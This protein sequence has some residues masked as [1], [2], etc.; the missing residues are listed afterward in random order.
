MEE[1]K[2]E[3]CLELE[4][5]SEE[6]LEALDLQERNEEIEALIEHIKD[7]Y[8][9]YAMTPVMISSLNIVLLQLLW[10]GCRRASKDIFVDYILPTKSEAASTKRKVRDLCSGAW[11]N[12]KKHLLD[13]TAQKEIAETLSVDEKYFVSANPQ[14]EPLLD[15]D[16][17]RLL[18]WYYYF[19]N[20][21]LYLDGDID[22]HL[23]KIFRDACKRR[24]L[25]KRSLTS[26]GVRAYKLRQTN[27]EIKLKNLR[28]TACVEK[29]S[30][31]I[32]WSEDK[33][34]LDFEYQNL[35]GE[36]WQMHARRKPVKD[37]DKVLY[38]IRHLE[39]SGRNI[40]QRDDMDVLLKL[41]SG[42]FWGALDPLL[43][44]K[45]SLKEKLALIEQWE[46]KWGEQLTMLKTKRLLL[47]SDLQKQE[48]LMNY[49]Q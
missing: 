46:Q 20:E 5:L 48:R 4:P 25:Y 12:F 43:K 11:K 24:L 37:F 33:L 23:C 49:E 8:K 18:F 35:V 29:M 28:E 9:E 10:T 41:S 44:E 16:G 14:V 39:V 21:A 27:H 42:D 45:D 40:I 30:E 2:A 13:E 7:Q 26:E 34:F 3:K 22:E 15:G 32:K 36:Y 17:Y 47:A 6:K 31:A 1:A 19:L 38:F